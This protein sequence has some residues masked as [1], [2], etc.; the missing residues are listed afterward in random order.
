MFQTFRTKNTESSLWFTDSELCS[1]LVIQR[2]N[3]ES[4]DEFLQ[5]ERNRRPVKRIY[6]EDQ[7][8]HRI[9]IRRKQK[10]NGH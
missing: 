10:N 4:Q 8:C 2:N 1:K 3:N 9:K 6:N 7:I 5:T